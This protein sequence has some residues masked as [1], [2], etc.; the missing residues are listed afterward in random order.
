MQS[1][2]P[3]FNAVDP[4]IDFLSAQG[5]WKFGRLTYRGR[6]PRVLVIEDVPLTLKKFVD[7]ISSHFP[8]ADLITAGSIRETKQCFVSIQKSMGEKSSQSGRADLVIHDFIIPPE[9]GQYCNFDVDAVGGHYDEAALESHFD[10]VLRKQECFELLLLVTAFLPNARRA[11]NERKAIQQEIMRLVGKFCIVKKDENIYDIVLAYLYRVLALNWRDNLLAEMGGFDFD[12]ISGRIPGPRV[13]FGEIPG[14]SEF[15]DF[16]KR[17]EVAWPFL[18]HWPEQES[19]VKSLLNAF[20]E[21]VME[22]FHVDDSGY[23]L[24]TGVGEVKIWAKLEQPLSR[25]SNLSPDAP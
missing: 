8:T 24:E 9:P 20:A 23:D 13:R 19:G 22:H 4:P 11:L 16:V 15:R 7:V 12:L 18:A 5:I 2:L 14:M 17:L 1:N 3:A 21:K 25:K 6:Q 10:D